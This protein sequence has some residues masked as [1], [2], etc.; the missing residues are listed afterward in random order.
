VDTIEPQVSDMG[1]NPVERI[2]ISLEQ[3]LA[4]IVFQELDR[5]LLKRPC[6]P[7]A[8]D[9]G[10]T[11]LVQTERQVLLRLCE[12]SRATAFCHSPVSFDSFVDPPDAAS[13]F[14]AG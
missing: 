11:N 13:L 14:E 4:L 12:I 3:F 5:C 8:I 10:V 9:H 7:N 1:H 6:R 2:H